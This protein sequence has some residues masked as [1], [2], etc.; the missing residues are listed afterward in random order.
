MNITLITPQSDLYKRKGIFNKSLRYAPL[1]MTT[2][3]ALAP[4]EVN[5][6]FTLIDEGVEDLNL[7]TIDADLAGITCITP[8][9]YRT[10]KIADTLRK[11]GI[12]VV[13]GG[14]HATLMPNEVMR[15]ADAIVMG[16][17]D[18]AWPA[19]LKDFKKGKLKK[20]YV[21]EKNF[22]FRDVPE[23]RRDLLKENG[24]LTINTVQASRGCPYHCLFCV[25]PVTWPGIYY[26]PVKEVIAE[27]EKLE[28]DTFLFLDLSPMEDTRYVKE[29]FRELIP[30]KKKW[31][32]LSTINIA[33]DREKLKLASQS[34]C[35]GLLI[36]YE[37]VM[38]QTISEIGKPFNNPQDY[39]KYTKL[40]H[41][42]G[43]AINACFVL[44]LDGDD[45][46]VFER[47]VEYV[48]KA[49]IDLPRFSVVT[50]FP[51]TPFFY[52]MK[53]NN[54]LLHEDWRY[55]TGQNV[56][57]NPKQMRP[58]ELQ[59]GLFWT[60]KNTY[61]ISSISK[62]I[63]ASS[64]AHSKTVF[65]LLAMANLGYRFYSKFLP[66]CVPVPCEVNPWRTAVSPVN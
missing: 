44:G 58:D 4:K 28:G 66:K 11:K 46:S 1:T 16:Y 52:R 53:K 37:S 24:Y 56:V 36:G 7:D 59:E 25:V 39:L 43:I 17:A 40:L 26:R 55:Y 64:A 13:I 61:S 45:K 22:I 3:A 27:I 51:G 18:T 15:H 20:K 65:S 48:I 50:P 62:R 5:P 49:A 21:Q 8:T 6:K 42:H 9:A 33:K 35:R 38:P 2:L 19:L 47:T 57:I 31:G 23:P 32:G 60:W 10:Y 29:L 63:F 41:D 54:R 14:V 34:G 30:L 12:K